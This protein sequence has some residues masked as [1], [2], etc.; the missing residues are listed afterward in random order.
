M[1]KERKEKEAKEKE[2]KEK[3]AKE[4]EV[5]QKE[6]KEKET[7]TKV[8]QLFHCHAGFQSLYSSLAAAC[9]RECQK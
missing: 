7:P 8:C 5:K 3:E 1:E 9:P 6:V 2:T 4:K